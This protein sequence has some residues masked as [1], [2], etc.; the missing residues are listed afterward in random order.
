MFLKIL[1]LL[2]KMTSEKVYRIGILSF[3]FFYI[4][5]LTYGI[6]FF[7]ADYINVISLSKEWHYDLLWRGEEFYFRPLENLVYWTSLH[8]FGVEELPLRIFK[9][10]LFMGVTFFIYYFVQK[11]TENHHIAFLAAL[12][13]GTLSAVLQS[14]TFIYDFEIVV[15]FFL[16]SATWFFFKAYGEE[17]PVWKNIV[18]FVVLVYLALITKESAKI[19]GGIIVVFILFNNWK[20]L[21]QWGI[22]LLIIFFISIKPGLLLGLDSKSDMV[23][24]ALLSWGDSNNFF[25]FLKYWLVSSYGIILTL[26]YIFFKKWHEKEECQENN[27]NTKKYLVFF[28][29]WFVLSSLLTILAPMADIRYAT[30]PM[31]PFIIFSFIGLYSLKFFKKKMKLLLIFLIVLTITTN[32]AFSLKYRYSFGSFVTL[33]DDVYEYTEQE[34]SNRIIMYTDKNPKYYGRESSVNN[35][36]RVYD[37]GDP[38]QLPKSNTNNTLYL[39]L[40]KALVN[41]LH[42]GIVLEKTIIKG[43]HCSMVYRPTNGSVEEI[44]LG[45]KEGDTTLEKTYSYSFPENNKPHSCSVQIGTRFLMPQKIQITMMGEKEEITEEIQPPLGKYKICEYRCP[46]F[47]DTANDIKKIEIHSPENIFNR[48]D[49]PHLYVDE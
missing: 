21:K 7:W 42:T 32:T 20:K 41:G 8:L 26:V 15:Q 23:F 34:Y 48:V 46:S 36:H 17:K 5:L 13:Y 9:A 39:A 11:S 43:P 22:P 28:G 45:I 16:L 29:V 33:V 47:S 2:K 49:P 30:I 10:L 12:F 19:Y 3:S 4:F 40:E 31:L 27:T 18:I 24:S 14:V 38:F 25:L 6:P 1:Y 35:T 37:Q 44:S